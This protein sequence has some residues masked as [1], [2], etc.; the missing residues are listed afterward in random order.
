MRLF[1]RQQEQADNGAGYFYKRATVVQRRRV[2]LQF[3]ANR[4]KSEGYIGKTCFF[5]PSRYFTGTKWS[6]ITSRGLVGER[7]SW[8]HTEQPLFSLK[9]RYGCI[10]KALFLSIGKGARQGEGGGVRLR[11]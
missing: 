1:V 5:S 6:E 4:A 8:F 11:S 3:I 9:L 10:C 7:R 2:L